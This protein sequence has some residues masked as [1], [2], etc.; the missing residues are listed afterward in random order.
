MLGG[1]DVVG[2]AV[3]A[4]VPAEPVTVVTVPLVVVVVVPAVVEGGSV[5][6]GRVETG[7]SG[8]SSI[9]SNTRAAQAS[10]FCSSVT[11]PEISLNGL[12]YWFA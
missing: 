12:V 3:D 7:V 11:T 6:S 4:V 10:A 8:S 1:G 5:T 2:G 9:S